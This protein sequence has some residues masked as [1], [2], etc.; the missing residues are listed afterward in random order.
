MAE[1][2]SNL[3]QEP[4]GEVNAWKTDNGIRVK[5]TILMKPY[6]EN[7]QTGLAIDASRSMTELF[8]TPGSA[9]FPGKP[10]YVEPVARKM[11]EYLARFDSDGETSAIYYACGKMGAVTH[12][13]GDLDAD[14]A[15]R[16][17]FSIPADA[18]T[19][20]QLVPAIK[21]FLEHFQDSPWT[22][23]LFITDGLIDDLEEAKKLSK[24]ICEDMRDGKRGF[25][26]F[27]IIGLGSEFADPTSAACKALEELD[28]LDE[29]PLYSVEGQDLWDHK[30]ALNMQT[31]EQIFAEVVDSNA[32]LCPSGASVVDSF[33]HEV[34]PEDG[35]SYSDGLPA[36]LRFTMSGQ[37]TSFTLC[38]PNGMKVEQDLSS[39]L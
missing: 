39:I 38:L 23:C 4:F 14:R 12:F 28:D 26:K 1:L 2:N 6:V 34:E 8:G 16:Q 36:M 31:M 9:F 13:I 37:S 30:L 29:D 7:A 27:V 21:F 5:A 19:G 33:G 32:I 17:T 20:T 3:V 24:C 22:I 11:C 15:L 18:G 10:N 35:S 25:T